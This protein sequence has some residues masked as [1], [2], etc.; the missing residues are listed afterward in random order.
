MNDFA[1]TRDI[2]HIAS[3][4]CLVCFTYQADKLFLVFWGLVSPKRILTPEFP[5]ILGSGCRLRHG[6]GQEDATNNTDEKPRLVQLSSINELLWDASS[7]S[8]Q[9]KHP[10]STYA[11]AGAVRQPIDLQSLER[12]IS[13]NVPAIKLPIDLK[14]VCTHP[15]L[16]RDTTNHYSL[17]LDNQTLPIKSQGKM[18]RSLW[19]ARNRRENYSRRLHIRSK[20][21]TRLYMLSKRPMYLYRRHIASAKTAV[22]LVRHSI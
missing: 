22:L 12:Y 6:H 20:G 21:N 16:S 9:I 18:A 5:R 19:C 13:Q 17:A 3:L 8:Q 10:S 7:K 11:M 4:K 14:Q 2:D 1:L 15:L